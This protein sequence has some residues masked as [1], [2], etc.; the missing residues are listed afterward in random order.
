MKLKKQSQ[1]EA[2]IKEQTNRHSEDRPAVRVVFLGCDSS[3][4][5]SL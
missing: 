4:S 3:V 5:G 2:K 1:K